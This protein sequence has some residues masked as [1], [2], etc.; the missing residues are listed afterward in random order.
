M[1]HVKHVPMRNCVLCGD[2]KPKQDMLRIVRTLDGSVML[3]ERGLMAGRGCY[4]CLDA[5]K[6]DERKIKDKIR[7]ALKLGNQ[8]PAD[9][10]ERLAQ[11]V[12]SV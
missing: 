10:L 1:A 9:L 4:V 3:D 6:F 8:V 2:K 11:R 5:T 7:R 12:N